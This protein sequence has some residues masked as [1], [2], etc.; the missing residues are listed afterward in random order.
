MW[1]SP[2]SCDLWLVYTARHPCRLPS[3]VSLAA[4]V[5]P[6]H[7]SLLMDLCLTVHHLLEPACFAGCGVWR[8]FEMTVSVS[9]IF[10]RTVLALLPPPTPSFFTML[11]APPPLFS[12]LAFPLFSD[13]VVQPLPACAAVLWSP[14]LLLGFKWDPTQCTTQLA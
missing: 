9:I 11:S 4:A 13:L 2:R 14:P 5:V 10:P 12:L 1:L 7:E 6:C 3:G 8:A